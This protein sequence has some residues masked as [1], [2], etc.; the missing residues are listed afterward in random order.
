VYVATGED[1]WP[2]FKSPEGKH[3]VR[4]DEHWCLGM[5]DSH[6][7][8]NLTVKINIW[9][10]DDVSIWNE[11]DENWHSFEASPHCDQH[12]CDHRSTTAIS[13]LDTDAEVSERTGRLQRC[14]QALGR[15]MEEL[16]SDHEDSL[17][18]QIEFAL[19]LGQMGRAVEAEPL[20][21]VALKKLSKPEAP[22]EDLDDE[23]EDL[24]DGTVSTRARDW[25]RSAMRSSLSGVAWST[26]NEDRFKFPG[27]RGMTWRPDT[28]PGM[29][30]AWMQ[31][32]KAD[33]VAHA[34]SL[35]RVRER[36]GRVLCRTRQQTDKLAVKQ[37]AAN[38]NKRRIGQSYGVRTGRHSPA[39]LLRANGEPPKPVVGDRLEYCFKV[40]GE[41]Q[42]FGGTV[43][44]VWADADE[45]ADMRFDDGDNLCVK[46]PP[47][48]EGK[49]WRRVG[50]QEH[51]QWPKKQATTADVSPGAL[52]P[53]A[54]GPEEPMADD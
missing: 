9:D 44:R 21:K 33:E 40:H 34:E 30:A 6:D 46:V 17:A 11:D 16:G 8:I 43:K 49:V 45:W 36:R 12:Q 32:T 26:R 15:K 24:D 37:K 19:C 48:A 47:N 10:E 7:E 41:S 35:R 4:N 5:R 20:L 53:A 1:G 42:W 52:S 39:T 54:A 3:L 2:S 14:E 13:L 50:E 22:D 38:P 18:S 31:P 29:E 25:L 27:Y 28:Y 23:D 51:Q